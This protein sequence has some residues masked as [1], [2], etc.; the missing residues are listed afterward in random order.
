MEEKPFISNLL[1]QCLILALSH[2][3]LKLSVDFIGLLITLVFLSTRR[4]PNFRVNLSFIVIPA[5]TS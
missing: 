1:L 3:T 4:H 2:A 5:P